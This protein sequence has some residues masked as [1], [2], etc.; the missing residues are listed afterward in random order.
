MYAQDYDNAMIPLSNPSGDVMSAES[1]EPWMA[2]LCYAPNARIGE[3]LKP[4]HLAILYEQGHIRDPEVFY[5]PAQPRIAEYPIPYYYEFYTGHGNY[6]WG[7]QLPTIPGVEGVTSTYGRRTTTGR[8]AK[9]ECTNCPQRVILVDNLQEWEV[10]PHRRGASRPQGISALFGDGHVN[11]CVGDDLF[12]EAVWPREPGWYN[13]PGDSLTAFK[14]I[15][16][17]VANSHQ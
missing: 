15:L 6:L 12:D 8:T 5:C 13:G 14:E 9:D 10:V 11:F 2:V 3:T 1:L 16:R 17:R 4:L 7:S